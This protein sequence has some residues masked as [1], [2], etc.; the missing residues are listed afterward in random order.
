MPLSEACQRGRDIWEEVSGERVQSNQITSDQKIY[1]ISLAQEAQIA[2]EIIVQRTNAVEAIES[3]C[4]TKHLKAI[5]VHDD[6]HCMPRAVAAWVYGSEDHHDEVRA[7]IAAKMQEAKDAHEDWSNCYDDNEI[8]ATAG[9]GWMGQ[10]HGKATAEA[11]QVSVE[12]VDVAAMLKDQAAHRFMSDP[13][14]G[15]T[16]R[17]LLLFHHVNHYWVGVP[18][19][20][21]T[22]ETEANSKRAR[23]QEPS[24]DA[25]KMTTIVQ[26][27]QCRKRSSRSTKI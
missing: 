5:A 6:G 17:K 10:E 22:N 14:T 26:A 27:W 3:E 19:A 15:A 7:L 18:P 9:I 20:D 11:F 13:E 21:E 12:L 23:V 2:E 25:T 8:K 16:D 4:A 1:F 24:K